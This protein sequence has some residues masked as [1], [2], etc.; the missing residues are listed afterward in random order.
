MPPKAQITREMIIGAG[1]KTVRS[2]G[3]EALN[4]RR[5]AAE[6]SCSTQPIMYQ[7]ASMEELKSEIYSAADRYHG[8]YIMSAELT[9]GNPMLAIGLQY[10]KFAAEERNLFRFLFQSDKFANNN[11]G[12]LIEDEALAPIFEVLREQT[13]L[14]S[15]QSREAFTALFLAVHGI[16]SLLANNSMEYDEEYFAKTLTNIFLG[17]IGMMKGGAI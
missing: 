15:E 3:A 5:I 2:E 12:G 17:V 9:S 14:T 1:L 13:G 10:I 7:F 11:I 16:A 4:V 8:E 6:L